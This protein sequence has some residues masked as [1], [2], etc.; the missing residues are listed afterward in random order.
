M[1]YA[2]LNDDTKLV[3]TI[4]LIAK[5]D[6]KKMQETSDFVELPP[7]SDFSESQIGNVDEKFADMGDRMDL[8]DVLFR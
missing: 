4:F 3:E 5:T 1:H 2:A 6:P 7:D 8:I